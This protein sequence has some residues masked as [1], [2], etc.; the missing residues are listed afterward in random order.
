MCGC[1][2][3]AVGNVDPVSVFAGGLVAVLPAGHGRIAQRRPGQPDLAVAG[4]RGEARRFGRDGNRGCC[5]LVG[6]HAVAAGVHGADLEGVGGSVGQ[7][8]HGV[9]GRGCIAA[10]DVG[11]VSVFAGGLVA[12]L[13]AGDAAVA[14]VG[15]A[16]RDL[17]V[18]RRRGAARGLRR[19]GQYR[20]HRHFVRCRALAS[21]V[22]SANPECMN[23]A[24]G[25]PGDGVGGRRCRA[26][27][28]VGPASV[29][30]C[31]LVGVLPFGNGCVRRIVPRQRR[32][33]VARCRRKACRFGRRRRLRRHRSLV[34]LLAVRIVCRA[35]LECVRGA[36]HQAGDGMPGCACA[37]AGHVG[38]L[39]AVVAAG[40]LVVVFPARD[41]GVV[42]VV[43]C[44][45][46]PAVAGF[47][48]EARRLGGRCFAGR[49]GRLVGR[50]AAAAPVDRAKPESI[51]RIVGQA[52]HRV[53]D[54]RGAAAGD[55]RP[56]AVIPRR[57]E[58]V[59]PAGDA[60]VA[61]VGPEQPCLRV[62]RLGPEAG[63]LRRR[64][65]GRGGDAFGLRPIAAAVDG[66]DPEYVLHTVGE[67]RDGVLRSLGAA[68]GN[69]GPRAVDAGGLPGILPLGD[70]GVQ[71]VVPFENDLRIPRGDGEARRLSRDGQRRCGNLVGLRAVADIVYRPYPDRIGRSV[72]QA[73]DRVAG[74]GCAA[75]G[76]V[77]PASVIARCLVGVLPFLDGCIGRVGPLQGN[78]SVARQR[79]EARRLPGHARHRSRRNL[80]RFRALA[81]IIDG[82]N[83][84]CVKR[85]VC[86]HGNDMAHCVGAAAGH[87]DP[88]AVIFRRLV[89]VLPFRDGVVVRVV[90]GQRGLAVSRLNRK[91]GGLFGNRGHRRRGFFIRPVSGPGVVPGLNLER[92]ASSVFETR[93]GI[94]CRPCVGT[95]N[96]QPSPI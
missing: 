69:I 65:P 24:I 29:A 37:A 21:A 10:C 72:G 95:G 70:R 77:R 58:A 59:L 38:P 66:P 25:E 71:R 23:D 68:A 50:R 89:G 20:C 42:R 3:A 86:E 40:C 17:P 64:R 28:N 7:P 63:R 76:H 36:V 60:A 79:G 51:S 81:D 94:A 2:C 46:D 39:G 90:P 30:A 11:P 16:Q 12:V 80:V 78:L 61:G 27:G 55:V 85:V 87:V 62:A 41:A 56:D 15:P 91:T 44:Q 1:G 74:S 83:P 5:R 4:R 92:V 43:P 57:L 22:H 93:D 6:F 67:A 33:A 96:R 88:G 34:R 13:P 14:G 32:P 26:V 53:A 31:R 18:A 52:G 54:R 75:A 84:E 19:R 9:G 35:N 73:A 49:R 47:G 48:S 82:A 45:H 8:G